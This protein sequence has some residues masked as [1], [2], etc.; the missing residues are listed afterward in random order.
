RMLEVP[1]IDGRGLRPA[2]DKAGTGGHRDERQQKR[3]NGVDVDEG[4]ERNTAE[5]ARRVIAKTTGGPRVRGFMHCKRKQQNEKPYDD[6]G[7]VTVGQD[8]ESITCYLPAKY[9]STASAVF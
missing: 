9:P 8:H 5:T 2:E 7:H 4:I 3:S 6:G 1:D